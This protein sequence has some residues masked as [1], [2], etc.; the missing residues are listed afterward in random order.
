MMAARS[1]L[2]S[3]KE[4]PP[5]G[6]RGLSVTRSGVR[7]E[8]Q[9]ERELGCTFPVARGD[10][11]KGR[12]LEVVVGGAELGL[13]EGVESLRPE[14]QAVSFGDLKVLAQAQVPVIASLGCV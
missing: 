2:Y 3:I 11:A 5:P 14:L 9:P 4:K 8:V 6:G 10:G 7:L 12:V 1:M 13:V